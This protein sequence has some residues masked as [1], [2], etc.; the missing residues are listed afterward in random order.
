MDMRM[1]EMDGLTAVRAIRQGQAGETAR[2]T[3]VVALTA[4]AMA[5]DKRAAFAAGVDAYLIKPVD[6]AEL[7]RLLARLLADSAE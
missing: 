6:M 2:Q 1:P 3:P 7:A 5:E 4:H